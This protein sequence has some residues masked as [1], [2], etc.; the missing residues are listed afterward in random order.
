VFFGGLTGFLPLIVAK[1]CNPARSLGHFT[2]LLKQI[3]TSLLKPYGL[4]AGEQLC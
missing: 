1:K 2:S 4:I 3:G